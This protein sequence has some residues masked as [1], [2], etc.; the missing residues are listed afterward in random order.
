MGCVG[1]KNNKVKGAKSWA[2]FESEEA[3]KD[4]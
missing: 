4:I 2:R 3:L 1:P